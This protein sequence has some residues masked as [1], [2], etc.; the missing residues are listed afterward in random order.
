MA[1]RKRDFVFADVFAGCGGLSLGLLN[2]GWRGLF[3]IEKNPHAFATLKKN[4]IDG[5]QASFDW[6]LWLPK[7]PHDIDSALHKYKRELLSLRGTLDLLVGG[8]PCQGF[9]SAGRRDPNDP[10]NSLFKRYLKLVS[11]LQP[12]MLLIENVQGISLS[13]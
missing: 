9:S 2:A 12:K 13:F 8:P 1:I 10:R 3:A 11:Y 7:T 4:L 5:D 6:P